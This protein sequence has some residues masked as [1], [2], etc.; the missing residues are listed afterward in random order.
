MSQSMQQAARQ[1]LQQAGITYSQDSFIDR[2][3]NGDLC[4]VGLFLNAGI[5]VND[6]NSRGFT[7]L[8]KAAHIGFFPM[9]RLLATCRGADVNQK[10]R[11]GW[12]PLM[13]AAQEGYRQEGC[14]KVV[15]FLVGEDEWSVC[16]TGDTADVTAINNN[17]ETALMIAKKS[18]A[19][20]EL[21]DCLKKA[22]ATRSGP[23]PTA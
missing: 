18:G 19:P 17:G 6:Q 9:V 12:T 22:E 2:V 21:I 14:T 8:M 4:T 23:S 15:C 16:I 20:Q 10:G 3:E 1:K 7:A 13:L 5:N 11:A